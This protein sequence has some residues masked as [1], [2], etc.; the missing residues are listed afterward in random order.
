M[1]SFRLTA[2]P[3]F[4]QGAALGLYAAATYPGGSPLTGQAP[5]V[6]PLQTQVVAAN[7]FAT[8]TELEELTGYIAGAQVGGV[9][10]F[11]AFR[12]TGAPPGGVSLAGVESAITAERA[13]ATAQ[14]NALLRRV[15]ELPEGAE[16]A[17]G[18][19]SSAGKLVFGLN[20]NSSKGHSATWT[21]ANILGD[22]S[23]HL[24]VDYGES[25][26]T[27]SSAVGTSLADGCTVPL[28]I[29][30]TPE[31]TVLHAINPAT[32][33]ASVKA[34]V[35]RVKADHPTVTTFELINEPPFKGPHRKSNAVDYAAIVKATYEACAGLLST[36]TLLVAAWATYEIV[37]EAGVQTGTFSDIHH[38]GGWLH[39]I[40]HSAHGPYLKEHV[41]GWVSH[42]YGAASGAANSEGTGG[43]ASASDQ[44]AKAVSEGFNATGTNNWWITEVGF[45]IGGG[46]AE[47]VPTAAAQAAALQTIL[48]TA[49]GYYTQGWLKA[50]FIYDDGNSG[51]NIYGREAQTVYTT[52]A[53]AHKEALHGLAQNLVGE[54]SLV[55]RSVTERKL[56]DES[57]SSRT[58]RA[59]AVGERALAA[60][61]RPVGIVARVRAMATANV[62]IANP[63]T[64]TF[65]GITFATGQLLLLR[66]QSTS[67]QN[68]PW[69]FATSATPLTRPSWFNAEIPPVLIDGTTILVTR[70]ELHE[71]TTWTLTSNAVVVDTNTQVWVN[72]PGLHGASHGETGGDPL[73]AESV[74]RAM[75]K[76]GQINRSR[77]A[78][79]VR[80]VLALETGR[81]APLEGAV[82]ST[83]PAPA[84]TAA[85][86][87]YVSPEGAT[88]I[89]A[90]VASR[91]EGVGFVVKLSGASS[92]RINWA[93]YP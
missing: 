68:G 81:T 20:S 43:F 30:N 13:R 53:T 1:V 50:I 86:P 12:T 63:G 85:G 27:V 70:G 7:G 15:E 45:N 44:H 38:E 37:T 19:A 91:T 28:V 71:D 48:N 69:V 61:L 23:D 18:G 31:S 11:S 76:E 17:E 78:S 42:A 5:G 77:L 83:I 93:V 39:D 59:E 56:G 40:A 6:P 73:P 36:T 51:F 72:T 62:N 84:T 21:A 41:N 65:D 82:E 10:R 88:S 75:I 89:S 49:L 47:G 80:T 4:P 90:V 29:I 3:T 46:G 74:A 22:R 2:S 92:D 26:A 60:A 8:F 52:F 32:Y 67:S 87:I 66:G 25:P 58:L 24:D 79:E 35:E 9:W 55:D 64:A 14:E 34:I 54:G 57:V 16:P 33:A